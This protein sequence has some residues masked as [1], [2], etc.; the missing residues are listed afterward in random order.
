MNNAERR[1]TYHGIIDILTHYHII[2]YPYLGLKIFTILITP[3]DFNNL[4]NAMNLPLDPSLVPKYHPKY[5][6]VTKRKYYPILGKHIDWGIF[7]FV[8]KFRDKEEYES[9][10]KVVLVFF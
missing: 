10:H 9:I 7:Y 1:K 2:C 4:L 5:A 3:W 8:D 6:S